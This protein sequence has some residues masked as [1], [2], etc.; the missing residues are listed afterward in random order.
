MSFPHMSG[1]DHFL[2]A[3]RLLTVAA[4]R[5]EDAMGANGPEVQAR[6]RARGR[7]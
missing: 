2:E 4:D 7:R 5:T 1:P 6:G 3:Q